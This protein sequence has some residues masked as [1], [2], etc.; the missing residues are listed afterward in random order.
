MFVAFILSKNGAPAV[1]L[2][3]DCRPAGA[4]FFI[5]RSFF[6][7]FLCGLGANGRLDGHLERERE[8]LQTMT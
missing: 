3:I 1:R 6:S 7:C 8:R 2:S 5:I 4:P